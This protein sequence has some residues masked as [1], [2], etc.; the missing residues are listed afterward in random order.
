M[1]LQ[2]YNELNE[3]NELNELNR[4]YICPQSLEKTTKNMSIQ[5]ILKNKHF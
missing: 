4:L 2:I 3:Q 1:N 5:P